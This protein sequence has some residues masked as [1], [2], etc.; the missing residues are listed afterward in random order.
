MRKR[1]RPARRAPISQVYFTVVGENKPGR[2]VLSLNDF[3][4]PAA[5]IPLTIARKYDSLE[6]S[7]NGD[8]GYGWSLGIYATRLAVA[9]DQS[10]TF[11]DPASGRRVNFGFT[12]RAYGGLMSF[13]YEAAYTGEQGVYGK[14]TDDGCGVLYQSGR[15]YR[16]TCS[17][18]YAPT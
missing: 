6:R 11:T 18:T 3:T 12:P 16:F 17:N 7:V 10:V 4:V 8:F 1:Q 15:Q 5:G 9:P 2:V 13:L 14:L